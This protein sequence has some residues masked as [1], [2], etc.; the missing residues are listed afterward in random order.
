ME[1]ITDKKLRTIQLKAEAKDKAVNPISLLPE[2]SLSG[3]YTSD[4]QFLRRFTYFW[5][6]M[7][8]L[9]VHGYMRGAVS[10]VGR[11]VAGINWDIIKDTE[12][13]KRDAPEKKRKEL[14]DFYLGRNLP[15]RNIK[16]FQAPST[17][18]MIAS[19]Y[20]KYF[21]M[22]AFHVL[23][24][25][26]GVPIGMEFLSGLVVPNVEETGTF[27]SPAFRQYT[28][29]SLASVVDYPNP[30]DIVYI[31]NPSFVGDPSGSSD[32]ESLSS[33]SL[34][35][36]I[37]L[38]LAAREYMKNRNV[39]EV[40]FQL[41]ADISDEAFDAF[42]E[43]LRNK[44]SGAS[45]IGK[46]PIAVAGEL[47]ILEL[48][49]LPQDL[50]YEQS[51]TATRD[52]YLATIGVFPSK[53]GLPVEGGNTAL[54][55]MRREYHETTIRPILKVLEESFNKQIHARLFGTIGWLF[56]FKNPD[57][58]NAVE[59]ATVHM[60]YHQIGV[61]SP[62]DIRRDLGLPE[63]L[64]EGGDKYSD[65]VEEEEQGSPP[66]GREDRPDAPEETG[67]PTDDNQDPPRGDQHDDEWSDDR[68]LRIAIIKAMQDELENWK[69][70]SVK[71]FKSGDT[72]REFEP[73]FIPK[74]FAD[75]IKEEIKEVDNVSIVREIFD[76][77]LSEIRDTIKE[78]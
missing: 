33:F 36:D 70:F 23:R 29:S 44:Y 1:I 66:E 40:I 26:S 37:Y 63:R 14:L 24:N 13:P 27:K 59:K 46:N 60:R 49:K 10:V 54:K 56:Q 75:R 74:I 6:L 2:I 45:N 42:E 25:S 9:L 69:S 3:A 17:S 11:T 38:Q 55:E 67:E 31:T 39:P 35:L 62:N 52:E 19:M 47:S 16:D 50:P 68:V 20:L 4:E 41:P 18:I 57:F 77:L 21:G 28:T 34:P 78:K 53:L 43:M 48:S 73:F 64:D 12:L 51:R 30:Q 61:L 8:T 5:D 22:A 65:E 32:A 72:T 71:R 15:I 76:K 7:D 58:L